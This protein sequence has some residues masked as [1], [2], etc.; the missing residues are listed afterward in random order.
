MH[1]DAEDE[2]DDGNLIEGDQT[3]PVH[4]HACELPAA[5]VA[6]LTASGAQ[7]DPKSF[8]LDGGP[9]LLHVVVLLLEEV[10][11]DME[12]FPPRPRSRLPSRERQ[13]SDDQSRFKK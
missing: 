8:G 9:K 2:L 4:V 11:D 10:S 5:S 3:Q 12:G 6:A 1:E 7:G 13:E